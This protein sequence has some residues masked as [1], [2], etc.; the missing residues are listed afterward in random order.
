MASR[1]TITARAGL[2][3]AVDDSLPK[4]ASFEFYVKDRNASVRFTGRSFVLPRIGQNGIPVISVN[5]PKAKLALYRIGDRNLIS[6]VV[7]SD[8]RQQIS[9]YGARTSPTAR[10]RKSGPARWTRQRRSTRR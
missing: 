10:A 2:P 1:Y 5:S 4:D 9:G 6:S 8:F 7:N 3:A